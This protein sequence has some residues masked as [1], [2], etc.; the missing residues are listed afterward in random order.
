MSLSKRLYEEG[1]LNTYRSPK[2][3]ALRD[4]SVQEALALELE[5]IHSSLELCDEGYLDDRAHWMER[6][7]Q[8]MVYQVSR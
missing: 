4:L 8:Y 1:L 2:E 7:R 6:L 5:A 3:E